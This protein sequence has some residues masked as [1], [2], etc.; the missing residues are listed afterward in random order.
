MTIYADMIIFSLQKAGGISVLWAEFIKRAHRDGLDM[1][2][3]LSK[4]WDSNAVFRE[5]GHVVSGGNENTLPVQI[6]RCFPIK[7]RISGKSIVH[8]SYYR[9]SRSLNAIN[10]VT[11]YDFTTNFYGKNGIKK[12][13][14][15]LQKAYAIKHSDGIICISESTK[16]DLLRMYPKVEPSKIRVIH[17]GVGDDYFP[18]ECDDVA[19]SECIV[20]VGGRGGYKKFDFAIELV[21]RTACSF[22]IVG[23]GELSAREKEMLDEVLPGRYTFIEWVPN[24]ELNKIY[25]T[26][27]CL[28][29]P[30]EYEGFGIPVLEAMKAGCPV[31]AHNASSIPEAAGDAGIL[32]NDYE[33]ENWLNS[34][35]SLS[36]SIYR[37]KVIQKGFVHSQGFTWEK[38]YKETIK[39]Y[40]DVYGRCE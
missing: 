16:R 36:D 18:I 38:T 30:S 4:G 32:H 19:D 11:V 37:G 17:C 28:L 23:G 6:S 24:S 22:T 9:I 10:I 26:A 8:S 31:L 1:Q 3:I 20:F 5:L 21:S 33:H 14:H 40:E 29:Y 34:I 12:W 2:Y 27:I 15:I 7:R 39:F 25:N 13:A 35:K